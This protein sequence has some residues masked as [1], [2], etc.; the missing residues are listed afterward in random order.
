P[1]SHNRLCTR[2]FEG[3][4]PHIV[5][6]SDNMTYYIVSAGQKLALQASS[7]ADVTE[8]VWYLDDRFLCRL[9]PLQKYFTSLQDGDHTLSCVDDRGRMSSVSFHVHLSM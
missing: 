6:P 5:S 7:G 9:K 8:H 2:I 3:T 4:G 1:P